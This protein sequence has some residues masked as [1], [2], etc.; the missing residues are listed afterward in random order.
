MNTS[1]LANVV[2][3]KQAFISQRNDHFYI[4]NFLTIPKGDY[5]YLNEPLSENVNMNNRKIINCNEGKD[6]K[7]VYN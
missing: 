2:N 6:E 1:G 5:R 4:S 3:G 7:N